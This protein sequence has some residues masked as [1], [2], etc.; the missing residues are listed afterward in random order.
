V[1]LTGCGVLGVATKGDLKKQ[2]AALEQRDQERAAETQAVRDELESVR[3]ELA[4][5]ERTLATRVESVETDLAALDGVR[6]QINGLAL[7]LDDAKHQLTN[8]EGRTRLELERLDAGVS[9]A[10]SDAADARD[11]A[12]T[13]DEQGRAISSAYAEGLRAERRRLQRELEEIQEQLDS[14]GAV[15]RESQTLRRESDKR[16]AR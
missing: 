11:I 10:T 9:L 8:L 5:V 12:L 14:V 2:Q 16:V 4:E 6:E 13:A 3:G 1:L 15:A 7:R